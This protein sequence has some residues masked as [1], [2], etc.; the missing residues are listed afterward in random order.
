VAGTWRGMMI[1]LPAEYWHERF[2][3]QTPRQMARFLRQTAAHIRRAA[4][5][6]HPRGPKK[7]PPKMNK[8]HRGHLSTARILQ[9]R[10]TNI[11]KK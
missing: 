8:K 11:N 4:F 6:K 10:R 5:R 3:Q 2:A 9:Q 1:V 7:P